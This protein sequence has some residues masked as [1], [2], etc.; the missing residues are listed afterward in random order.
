MINGGGSRDDTTGRTLDHLKF[1]DELERET[2]EKR[3]TV[4]SAG[5]NQSVNKNGGTVGCEP[6]QLMLGR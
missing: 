4:I 6:R 3:F 2:K 5:C 1:M